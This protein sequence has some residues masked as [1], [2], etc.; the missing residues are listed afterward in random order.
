MIARSFIRSGFAIALAAVACLAVVNTA[1]AHSTTRQCGSLTVHGLACRQARTIMH[2]WQDS[3]AL[4]GRF[5]Y[6]NTWWSCSLGNAHHGKQLASCVSGQK[7]F[8]SLWPA[9][10]NSGQGPNGCQPKPA[11]LDSFDGSGDG[12]A[13]D[14]RLSVVDLEATK[15]IGCRFASNFS[16]YSYSHD[17]LRGSNGASRYS[18]RRLC[19]ALH[20]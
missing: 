12:Y 4:P 7:W 18:V 14:L 11:L 8:R 3:Y 13:L 17:L 6:G 20:H 1:T 5:R 2:A 9:D 16:V 19:L 15:G 10:W